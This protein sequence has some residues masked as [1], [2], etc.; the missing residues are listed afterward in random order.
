MRP[1]IAEIDQHHVAH[2]LGDKAVEPGDGLGDGTVIGGDDF[3]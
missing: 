1:R 3:A 2:V